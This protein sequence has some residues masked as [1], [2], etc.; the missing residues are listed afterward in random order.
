M[1]RGRAIP[2]WG[3]GV[4]PLFSLRRIFLRRSSTRRS[5]LS[6]PPGIWRIFR[7]RRWRFRLA[8]PDEWANVLVR[9]NHHLELKR[10]AGR[11][12]RYVVGPLAGACGL[13]DR[14]VQVPATGLGP[15]LLRLGRAQRRRNHPLPQNPR[16]SPVR[17]LVRRLHRAERPEVGLH[18]QPGAAHGAP[19]PPPTRAHI[20]FS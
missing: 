17:E 7:L 4:I 18:A 16:R 2:R 8:R 13:A 14:R 1:V 5:W 20:C 12:L 3:C 9:E 10:F 6:A 15:C 11:D 19:R